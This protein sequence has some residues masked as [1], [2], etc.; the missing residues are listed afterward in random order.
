MEEARSFRALLSLEETQYTI[1]Q[2]AA[3][4]AAR[5]L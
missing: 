2:I 4:M 3:K 5:R 1:E